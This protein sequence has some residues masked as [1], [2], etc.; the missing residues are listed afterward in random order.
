MML[1]CLSDEHVRYL[2]FLP[3]PCH[4]SVWY[5][6]FYLQLSIGRRFGGRREYWLFC[7]NFRELLKLY[8]ITRAA[9]A[10]LKCRK[11]TLANTQHFSGGSFLLLKPV[12][13]HSAKWI[14]ILLCTLH[15]AQSLAAQKRDTLHW[16][17]IIHCTA[18]RG[19]YKTKALQSQKSETWWVA[20][21]IGEQ[22]LIF[23]KKAKRSS[24]YEPRMEGGWMCSANKII[25]DGDE[26][27]WLRYLRE[28]FSESLLKI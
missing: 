25:R 5:L 15:T 17:E 3:C 13:I 24:K 1:F 7:E 26:D 11:K 2:C 27:S 22:R 19:T 23:R 18:V 9:A 20:E 21:N 4:L 10:N 6:L 14:V 28:N 16:V 12:N 8:L